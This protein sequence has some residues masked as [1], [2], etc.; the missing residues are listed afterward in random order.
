MKKILIVHNNYR[1]KGGEDIAL[2][3]EIEL[4]KQ[5]YN[6]Q[7]LSFQNDYK[8]P[9]FIFLSFITNK[10]YKSGKIFKKALNEFS[11]DLV[12]IHNTWFKA[13][14]VIFSI[15][16]KKDIP[17]ALKLHNFRYNCS[18]HL[19]KKNHLLKNEFCTACG[20]KNNGGIINKYFQES[21]LKSIFLIRYGKLYFN[22]LKKN[23]LK[24]F[25]LTEFHK[26]FLENLNIP[27]FK[28]K[29]F[30]NY[31]KSSIKNNLSNRENFI[32]YAGRISE[33]KGVEELI[34]QYLKLSDPPFSLKIV[35]EGPLL[36]Y[37]IDKY[38]TQKIEFL[39]E[40]S[41]DEVQKLMIS[42]IAIVS[43]TKLLEGQPTLLCEASILGKAS[44]FPNTEGI[45]EFFPP[46][47]K[48]SFQQ[49]NYD[50][51][52][53]KL[54]ML[55]QEDLLELEGKNNKKFISNKLNNESLINNFEKII[56]E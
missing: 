6:V 1:F 56:N 35:G 36:K 32:L 10:N 17:V 40:V 13:S 26:K 45:S 22:I 18:R 48:L 24:I 31:L 29:V 33:Q 50:N 15:L 55:S 42:S 51:L 3:N 37:L 54:N 12:Y 53:E 49:Y 16:K 43:A 5:K 8:N 2:V 25:V 4:L 11:P 38:Q 34:K 9:I 27:S 21:F 7:F 52:F 30:P 39:G 44:I 20:M 41:N 46:E 47:T 14:L 19:L 23:N 28:I